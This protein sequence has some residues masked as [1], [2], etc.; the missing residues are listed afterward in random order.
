MLEWSRSSQP[1]E[2]NK[3]PMHGKI[4]LLYYCT[5]CTS[6]SCFPG[7]SNIMF[8]NWRYATQFCGC[9][10]VKDPSLTVNV[11][12]NLKTQP[13][14]WKSN[15]LIS[16]SA[17]LIGSFHKAFFILSSEFRHQNNTNYKIQHQNTRCAN[18]S[19][20]TYKTMIQNKHGGVYEELGLQTMIQNLHF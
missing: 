20:S 15:H 6:Q 9:H 11:T 1:T 14:Q 4:Q 8:Q 19:F 16:K 7:R 18:Y 13:L 5:V 2:C 3:L 12:C 17:N 10:R